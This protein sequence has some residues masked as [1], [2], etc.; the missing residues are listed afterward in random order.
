MYFQY[1]TSTSVMPIPYTTIGTR[2]NS[3]NK[4]QKTI[5]ML[6]HFSSIGVEEIALS[7]ISKFMGTTI[8][9]ARWF[10]DKHRNKLYPEESYTTKGAPYP[11]T[12]NVEIWKNWIKHLTS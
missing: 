3:R 12:W 10:E 6:D 5:E 9:Q 7:D 1:D 11:S 8:R 4:K 2:M